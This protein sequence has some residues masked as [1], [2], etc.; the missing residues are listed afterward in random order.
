MFV[1]LIAFDAAVDPESL[2]RFLSRKCLLAGTPAASWYNDA[3][4]CSPVLR[5]WYREMSAVFTP[6][7]STGEPTCLLYGHYV[8]ASD[9]ACVTVPDNV[10]HL[11]EHH[12]SRIADQLQLGLMSISEN[13]P[14]VWLPAL[15]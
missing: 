15:R 5:Q 13:E 1:E 6:S 14:R 10:Q 11:A 3:G 7:G 8:F 4:R 9:I 12:A 2:A